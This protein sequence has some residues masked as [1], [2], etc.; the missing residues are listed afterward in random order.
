MWV[1]LIQKIIL[2]MN[3]IKKK[4]EEK[5]HDFF[6]YMCNNV[7]LQIKNNQTYDNEDKIL[8]LCQ[9]N[10]RLADGS[11]DKKGFDQ[12]MHDKNGDNWQQQASIRIEYWS[13]I[14]Q[15]EYDPNYQNKEYSAS[16]PKSEKD[17]NSSSKIDF[18]LIAIISLILSVAFMIL[19]SYQCFKFSWKSWKLRGYETVGKP[20]S[21]VVF[22]GE[23]TSNVV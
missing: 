4:N 1:I 22:L 17:Q 18:S 19:F 20:K 9:E 6:K 12:C 11:L 3:I 10:N 16:L 7:N 8:C 2:K 14:Y 15:K 13:Q 21:K 5:E 23:K